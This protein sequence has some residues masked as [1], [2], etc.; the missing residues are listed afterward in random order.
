MSP[1]SFLSGGSPLNL[2]VSMGLNYMRLETFGTIYS[3]MK[4]IL[5]YIVRNVLW[6][7]CGL[8]TSLYYVIIA[9]S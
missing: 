2:E 4:C 7:I 6:I 1:D 5:P 8:F 9:L 3:R